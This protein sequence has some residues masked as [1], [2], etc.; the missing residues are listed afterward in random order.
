M[1][2]EICGKKAVYRFSPDL[3]IAGLGSCK[4]HKRDMQQAIILL[5]SEGKKEYEDFIKSRTK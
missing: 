4:K 3:D 2:C 5:L 1:K